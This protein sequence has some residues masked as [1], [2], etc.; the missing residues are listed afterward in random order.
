MSS[1]KL[2]LADKQAQIDALRAQLDRSAADSARLAEELRFSLSERA[3]TAERLAEAGV[4]V[5]TLE[6]KVEGLHKENGALRE[7]NAV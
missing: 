2:Q 5:Q 6:Q 1:S 7:E 4:R 3:S